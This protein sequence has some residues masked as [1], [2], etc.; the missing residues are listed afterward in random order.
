MDRGQFTDFQRVDSI[1]RRAL[2]L[3]PDDRDAFLIDACGRDSRLL[4]RV[5]DLLELAIDESGPMVPGGG[6]RAA[7]AADMAAVAGSASVGERF[8]PWR[9]LEEIGRGGMALVYRAER[10]D[11]A[12]RQQVAIKLLHRIGGSMSAE[13]RFE[14]ERNLL[15]RL[16]HPNIS[17]LLDGGTTGDGRSYIV[18]EYVE[19][20][21]ID[22][23]C[24]RRKLSIGARLSLFADVCDAVQYAHD[25]LIVHRD[26]KP[27]NILVT[28][29]GVPKLLDFGIAKLMETDAQAGDLTRTG[30]AEQLLTP[31]Y[32]S[33]EQVL[34]EPVSKAADIYALGLLLYELLCGR[35]ARQIESTR[36]SRIEQAICETPSI[37][38]SQACTADIAAGAN[39]GPA[40]ASDI[41]AARE[42]T[43]ARLKR[44]LRGDL[45]NI[46]MMALR[47]EPERRYASAEQMAADIRSFL[48]VRPIRARPDSTLYRL[49]R[50][51]RRHSFGVATTCAMILLGAVIVT[52]VRTSIAWKEAAAPR[53]GRMAQLTSLAGVE[54]APSWSPDGRAVVYASDAADNLDLYIQDVDGGMARRL[55]ASQA[56]DALPAWSPDGTRVAFVSARARRE[57][58]LRMHPDLGSWTSFFPG[59]NGDIW[60]MPADGGEARMIA[61]DGY[62]PVWSPDGESLLFQA[63]RDGRWEF[64]IVAANGS[65]DG[66]V[67]PLGEFSA[68]LVR[69]QPAW[70]P[71]GEWIAFVGGLGDDLSLYVVPSGGGTPRELVRPTALTPA[72][73]ADG[74]WLYFSSTRGGAMNLWRARFDRGSLASEPQRLTTGRGEHLYARVSPSGKQVAYNSLRRSMNIWRL[75]LAGGGIRAAFRESALQDYARPSPDGRHIAFASNR[76]GDQHIWI[77]ERGNGALTR[78]SEFPATRSAWTPDGDRLLY[79][80]PDSVRAYDLEQRRTRSLYEGPVF[81][82]GGVSVTPDGTEAIFG[83]RPGGMGSAVQRVRLDLASGRT[84]PL[85]LPAVGPVFD[86]ALSPDGDKLAVYIQVGSR[87]RA[88]WTIPLTGDDAPRQLTAGDHEDSHPAW[89]ADGRVIYFVRNHQDLYAVAATGGDPWPITRFESF[90]TGVEYP[91]ATADGLGVLFS[92]VD[93]TG[94]IFL[95]RLTEPARGMSR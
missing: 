66:R 55:T 9:V 29:E 3:P 36:P 84:E 34:G 50:F 8:G 39:P 21:P 22:R 2:E 52:L 73:S 45:D 5:R 53:V 81:S 58:R 85:S 1:V 43:S 51:V 25:R 17:R 16:E 91:A 94:D 83:L 19:G 40:T 10:A 18:M 33:P 62:F 70:S 72:W 64:R 80:L 4:A 7:R 95:L 48:A 67:L 65:G 42:V 31:Q 32:A 20:E 28:A 35:R 57:Q 27:G 90:T 89:S 71:D 74:Q 75:D 87:G 82:F 6:L 93:K 30:L 60:V 15:A 12:Y 11:G 14:R 77:L 49:R 44:M 79:L 37:L 38:P 88:I 13:K 86:P 68:S 41:A 61:E 26:I 69:T 47:R 24:D 46:V 76:R 56:D 63:E 59:G 92:R 78:V 54:D 23:Y